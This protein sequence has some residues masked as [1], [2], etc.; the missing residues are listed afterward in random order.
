MFDIY[1]VLRMYLLRLRRL[2]K[3]C[4]ASKPIGMDEFSLK[5]Y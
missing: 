3:F 5:A 1:N 2:G 4:K